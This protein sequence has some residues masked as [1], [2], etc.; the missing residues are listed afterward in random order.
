MDSEPIDSGA[1]VY[2]WRGRSHL[3]LSRRAVVSVSGEEGH[4]RAVIEQ[5]LGPALVRVGAFEPGRCAHVGRQRRELGWVARVVERRVLVAD[6]LA[7][8]PA[9]LVKREEGEDLHSAVV[10]RA[11]IGS[12]GHGEEVAEAGTSAKSSSA[13]THAIHAGR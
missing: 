5:L 4:R 12:D 1:D 6:A 13:L 9:G 11:S 2:S 8:A 10:S 7:R 3:G